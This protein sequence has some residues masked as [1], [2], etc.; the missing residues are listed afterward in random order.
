MKILYQL[1]EGSIAVASF[2]N[3]NFKKRFIQRCSS[4]V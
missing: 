2:W 4:N 1:K 3:S